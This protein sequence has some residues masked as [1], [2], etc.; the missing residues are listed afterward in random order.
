[1]KKLA[2]LFAPLALLLAVPAFAAAKI[3]YKAQPA[4]PEEQAVAKVVESFIEA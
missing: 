2:I 4:T 1:M 3:E